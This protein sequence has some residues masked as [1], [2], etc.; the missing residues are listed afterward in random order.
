M[1]TFTHGD[2]T[3]YYEE[4]GEGFP[5]LTFAP[6]G[7]LSTCA[8][9]KEPSAPIDPVAEWSGEFRVI[10]MDQRNAPNGRSHAPITAQ[11]GWHSYTSDHVALLDHLGIERCHLYGQCIGGPFIMSFLKAAQQRVACAVIAQPSGRIGPMKPGRNALFEAFAQNAHARQPGLTE[12]TLDAFQRNLYEA[13]F[14]YSVDRE[15]VKTVRTPMLLMA[16]NDEAHPFPVS[17]EMSQ[18]L[19]DCEFIRE[20]KTGDALQA[21]RPRVRAFLKKHTPA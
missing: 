3:I 19:P 21:A 8:V 5:I 16:G 4:H 6:K 17:E 1:P 2:A 14:V 9:W 18:L 15:F 7:L 20:W 11:D 12:E 10:C 13:G